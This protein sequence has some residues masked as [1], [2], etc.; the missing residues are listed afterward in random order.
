M[1]RACF[2]QW[3]APRLWKNDKFEYD[4]L[5]NQKR[6]CCTHP[7][8]SARYRKV[9]NWHKRITPIQTS[10]C[11]DRPHGRC[12]F[13]FRVFRCQLP[14]PRKDMY[15][16]REPGSWNVP[17]GNSQSPRLEYAWYKRLNRNRNSN[18][19]DKKILIPGIIKWKRSED[20]GITLRLVDHSQVGKP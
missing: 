6:F 13:I 3:V 12:S 7:S 8:L 5:V 10:L 15:I 11:W 19:P 2:E 20:V 16:F 1:N 18:K 17:T 4:V 14:Q 9:V